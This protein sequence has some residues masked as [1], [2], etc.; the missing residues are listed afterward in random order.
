VHYKSLQEHIT[1]SEICE[2][3]CIPNIRWSDNG[4]TIAQAIAD[5]DA[6]AL[7]D[8]SF[9]AGYGMAAWVIEGMIHWRNVR[10]RNY[11]RVKGSTVSIQVS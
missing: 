8:G 10:N 6:I 5:G 7:S 9:K 1:T 11:F 3:W 2:S 4:S